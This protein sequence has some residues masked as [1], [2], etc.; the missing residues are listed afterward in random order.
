MERCALYLRL[1]KENLDRSSKEASE[2]IVN[3]RDLLVEYANSHGF[4]IILCKTQ[5]RFSRDLEV[6]E[7]YIRNKF[8][9]WGIRFIG[10]VDN[11][12][13]DIRAIKNPGRSMAWSTNGW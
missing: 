8:M 10:V 5:A 9:L 1:S 3:Q 13:T 7:R 12:D 4:E 2:S 11:D 6:V